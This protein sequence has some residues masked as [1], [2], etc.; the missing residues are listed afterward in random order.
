MLAEAAARIGDPH[1]RNMGTIGGSLAHA[2]PGADLPAVV[3][4]LGAELRAVGRGRTRTVPVDEFFI[5]MFG[6]AL[7]SDEM[8]VE[9]RVPLPAARTGG[10][11]EKHP[12]PASGYA[13]VGVAAVVTLD[14]AGA[15]RGARV[16]MTGLPSH[17][18][19]LTAVE[20]ALAG[21]APTPEAIESAAERAAEGLEVRDSGGGGV[22]YKRN[23]AIV[24]ARRA[25]AR[26]V[27]RARSG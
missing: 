25:L 15:V 24:Y 9:V 3:L 12:D 14:G 21:K 7:A 27:E 16:A 11:Y 4:A 13:L 26:A 8:L 5:G 22:E 20:N 2:D 17:A 19:R 1:V 6:T 18:V 23:L 10:A